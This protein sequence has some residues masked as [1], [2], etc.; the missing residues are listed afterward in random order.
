MKNCLLFLM[1]VALLSSC[2]ATKLKKILTEGPDAYSVYAVA[3]AVGEDVRVLKETHETFEDCLVNPEYTVKGYPN[4]F[5]INERFLDDSCMAAFSKAGLIE[6]DIKSDEGNSYL[7]DVRLTQSGR[8]H[9]VQRYISGFTNQLE[10]IEYVAIAYSEIDK[11]S[12]VKVHEKRT[13]PIKRENYSCVSDIELYATPFAG[14]LGIDVSEDALN[15]IHDIQEWEVYYS[16]S[17]ARYHTEKLPK[18]DLY[19]DFICYDLEHFTKEDALRDYLSFCVS[20]TLAEVC[21]EKIGGNWYY[22]QLYDPKYNVYR[23]YEELPDGI[24]E[25]CLSKSK[26]R[27]DYG[28]KDYYRCTFL[29]GTR[30]FGEIL[31]DREV[32]Q[33][34]N[35]GGTDMGYLPYREFIYTV[36]ADYTE[37]GA[38]EC[39]CDR[40]VLWYG[41]V[42]YVQYQ[43][44]LYLSEKR[45]VDHYWSLNKGF[46]MP[47]DY[48]EM[49][50]YTNYTRSPRPLYATV[51][52][53]SAKHLLQ[54]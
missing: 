53:E 18:D 41:K 27:T 37:Y 28:G 8:E 39:G 22:I 24:K 52:I 51:P 5:L 35:I 12:H 15:K 32:K 25:S 45:G 44:K 23:N 26:D 33:Y 49:K 7:C 43:N 40:S 10:S 21:H 54:Q 6:Y 3:I 42:R 36:L 48:T 47:R 4:A 17:G 31:R 50:K 30:K 19:N 38:I 46:L 16:Y 14:C 20:D 34:V 2:T 1:S 29:V 11:I 13:K 9:L